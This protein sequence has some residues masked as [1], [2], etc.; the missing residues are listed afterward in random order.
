MFLKYH[1]EEHILTV[2]VDGEPSDVIPK[3]LY[4]SIQ[5]NADGIDEINKSAFENLAIVIENIARRTFGLKE[6]PLMK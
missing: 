5:R 2:L 6:R 4:K 1:D 3:Q